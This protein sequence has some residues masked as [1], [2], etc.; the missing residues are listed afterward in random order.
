MGN[1]TDFDRFFVILIF[2]YVVLFLGIN[3]SFIS[4]YID[5]ELSQKNKISGNFVWITGRTPYE[6]CNN[7]DICEYGL[8]ESKSNCP[9]DCIYDVKNTHPRLL[10]SPED[11]EYWRN[12]L[13][14]YRIQGLKGHSDWLISSKY[15][16]EEII[17]QKVNQEWY[18]YA[19]DTN[20]L[21][22]I[23]LLTNDSKYINTSMI[24]IEE[25]L[26]VDSSFGNDQNQGSRLESLGYFYD[27]MYDLL[28]ESIKSK[29]RSEIINQ[30]ESDEINSFIIEP[31]FLLTHS[32]HINYKSLPAIISIYG[33]S[34]ST[35]LNNYFEKNVDNYIIENG[36]LDIAEYTLADGGH[37]FGFCYGEA[38]TTPYG[39]LIWDFSTNEE[40]WYIEKYNLRPLFYLYGF[41][42][43]LSLN[44][45]FPKS[46]DCW[47]TNCAEY[48]EVSALINNNKN[49]TNY[50][51]YK[52]NLHT[53]LIY[54]WT[55][56]ANQSDNLET[57]AP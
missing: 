51:W 8:N 1:R 6:P 31:Y 42:D 18:R 16:S 44:N 24:F 32:R 50:N 2:I 4:D 54:I 23:S 17:S 53:G 20:V 45:Y 57:K 12:N 7:N 30:L 46:G 41:R 13:S 52:K 3:I 26:K 9:N 35:L 14:D 25:I 22:L 38:Y 28:N 48:E 43:N 39:N 29:I 47:S 11:I 33:E 56:H 21:A 49:N 40:S 34:N 27:Y 10:F 5:T 37:F 55:L 19:Q 36:F 15:N